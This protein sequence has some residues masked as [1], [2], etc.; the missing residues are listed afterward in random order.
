MDPVY[1]RGKFAYKHMNIK[2]RSIRDPS[3]LKTIQL[4]IWNRKKGQTIKL[5]LLP[6]VPTKKNNI[7]GC[8]CHLYR[9]I[10]KYTEIIPLNKVI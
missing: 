1:C 9:K 2:E 10:Y 5:F 4:S 3:W 7:N 8:S 6:S